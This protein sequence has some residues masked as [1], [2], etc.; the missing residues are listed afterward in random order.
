MIQRERP[1]SD[2]GSAAAGPTGGASDLTAARAAGTRLL[3]AAADAINVALSGNSQ[4]FLD[5][6]RQRGGQ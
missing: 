3:A 6:V 4:Q 1:N 5:A 2:A